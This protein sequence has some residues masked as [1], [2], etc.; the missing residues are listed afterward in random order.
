MQM[1]LIEQSKITSSALV[2]VQSWAGI[3]ANCKYIYR[4]SSWSLWFI[5]NF[6][7]VMQNPHSS[8]R[9]LVTLS[10]PSN[11]QKYILLSKGSDIFLNIDTVQELSPHS[12]W[13]ARS[14]CS[15]YLQE[16]QREISMCQVFSTQ[17]YLIVIF[18]LNSML[19]FLN[20]QIVFWSFK[21]QTRPYTLCIWFITWPKAD[22]LMY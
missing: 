14:L 4:V 11:V 3:H 20:I 9:V 15:K 22:S 10:P 19:V 21:L 13:S 7:H 2:A 8:L 5:L 16:R 6:H 17:V 18:N 1:S 12:G